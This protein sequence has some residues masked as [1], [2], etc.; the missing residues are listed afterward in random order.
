MKKRICGA[1]AALLFCSTAVFSQD[2]HPGKIDFA[3]LTGF[4]ETNVTV[5]VQLGGWLLSWAQTAAR[6]DEDL[7]VL[8]KVESIRVKVFEVSERRDYQVQAD[9]V[10]RDLMDTGWER[11][12]RVIEPDSWVHV[13]VKGSADMLE[14]ITVIAMDESSEAVLVNIAGRLDPADVAALLDD[15]DLMHVDL[16]LDWD[17]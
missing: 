4:D 15:S 3:S 9:A 8:S 5:D 6:D 12:A 17:A 1:F 11:F 14:G 16:D 2:G 10:V 7:K 13:L